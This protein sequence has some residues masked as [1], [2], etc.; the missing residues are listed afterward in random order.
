[1]TGGATTETA[2][3]QD[4]SAPFGPAMCCAALVVKIKD[5][6][7]TSHGRWRAGYVNGKDF[8]RAY[9]A[10]QVDAFDAVLSWIAEEQRP[11]AKNPPRS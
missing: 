9:S 3:D 6:R 7:F 11:E 5:A 1:M 4:G 8:Q 10:G 2:I